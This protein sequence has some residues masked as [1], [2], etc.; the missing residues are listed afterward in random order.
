M[1]N[2]H[3]Q[4]DKPGIYANPLITTRILDVSDEGS[5]AILAALFDA[6]DQEAIRS[7]HQ[8]RIG[9]T[10]LWDNRGGIL[11]TGRLDCPRDQARRFIR[12][13]VSGGPMVAYR[14]E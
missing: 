4:S 9:D 7:E 1:V 13:T 14:P 11:H 10:L 5:E 3:S 6:L 2:A 12:T 8:W